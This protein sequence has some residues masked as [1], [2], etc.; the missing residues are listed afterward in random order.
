M[1]A[2]V[3][4]IGAGM[5]GASLASFLGDRARVT[6]IEGEALPG[7]HTTGR[8]AAFYAE[9][10]G[11]PGVQPLTTASRDFFLSPP[12]G[13]AGGPLLTPRGGLH[14]A[15]ADGADI[16]DDLAAD[17][18][19]SGVRIER[20]RAGD[21]VPSMADGWAG[22]ALWE[23]DCRDIDVAALHQGF[24]ASA[25]R[26]GARLVTDAMV[27]AI[28]RQAGR[29]RIDT[30]AGAIE[31]DVLV[32]AAGAWGDDIAALAGVAPLGLQPLRRTVVVADV[33]P[34][35]APDLPVVIAADGSFYFKPDAGR[36]WVSPHD[37]TPDAPSD[38]QPDE[39]D[40]A[41]ALDRLERATAFRVRRVERAWAGLR[42]FAPDRLPVFGHDPDAPDF[43][44]CVGQGGFGIQTAPAAGRLLAEH[45]LGLDAEQILPGFDRYLPGRLR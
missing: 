34:V 16:L 13:F 45:L 12:A 25:R 28:T 31:A 27:R 22:A 24:L 8:S 39:L 18:A 37:E 32:N 6:L 19:G 1:T 7:Y 15:A 20:V 3:A 4:I 38:V 26:S 44:W 5:A 33:A 40:V 14:V 9:T 2:D 23:P 29:W 36:L 43:V 41:I 35:P 10:Y 30:S 17:F 42:T 11:G 21:V